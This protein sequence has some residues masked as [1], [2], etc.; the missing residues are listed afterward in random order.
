MSWRQFKLQKQ[1]N[2]FLITLFQSVNLQIYVF[3]KYTE[4][5]YSNQYWINI[6]VE[7]LLD[8]KVVNLIKTNKHPL[9]ISSYVTL[10]HN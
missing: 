2:F 9:L 7:I 8:M 10:I 3:K 5:N 6:M 1:I 4:R